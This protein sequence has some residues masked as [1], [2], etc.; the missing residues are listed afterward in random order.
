MNT[1]QY[2]N[3]LQSALSSKPASFLTS[4]S[5]DNRVATAS[6][7]CYMSVHTEVILDTQTQRQQQQQQNDYTNLPTGLCTI[8]LTIEIIISILYEMSLMLLQSLKSYPFF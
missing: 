1:L 2:I 6:V 5:S 3:I 7:S 4:F 8:N